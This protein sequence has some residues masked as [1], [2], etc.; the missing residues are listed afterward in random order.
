V[1]DILLEHFG[2]DEL[3]DSQFGQLRFES[4]SSLELK[5]SLLKLF[6]LDFKLTSGDKSDSRKLEICNRSWET[7]RVPEADM[8][9]WGCPSL[10]NMC[11]PEALGSQ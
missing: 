9:L 8:I 3:P 7:G 5:G 6:F 1:N 2:A 11:S 10:Q 4:R